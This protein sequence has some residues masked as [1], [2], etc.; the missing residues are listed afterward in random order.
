MFYFIG[1]TKC[2]ISFIFLLLHARVQCVR[3]M[4]TLHYGPPNPSMLPMPMY[5]AIH[6]WNTGNATPVISRYKIGIIMATNL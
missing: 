1:V 2:F 3:F 5:F 6:L 4:H